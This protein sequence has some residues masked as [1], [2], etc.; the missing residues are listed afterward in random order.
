MS[1]YVAMQV[2][3]FC[4][5]PMGI[6]LDRRL[7]KSFHSKEICTGYDPCDTC[8]E[9]MSHGITLIEVSTS[10]RDATQLPMQEGAYPT[11]AWW[12]V[13]EAAFTKP[14]EHKV[15]FVTMEVVEKLGLYDNNK[16]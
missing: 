15:Q 8:K 5:E 2:C 9:K 12:V 16:D 13:K 7:K 14:Q 6:L 4:G 11:G 1:S 3:F 10:P